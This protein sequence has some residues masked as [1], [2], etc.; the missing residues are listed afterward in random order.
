MGWVW[1]LAKRSV[2]EFNDDDCAHLAAGVAYYALFSL[3][4]LLLGII[5]ILGVI[6]GSSDV[7]Q[8]IMDRV[9]DL[10]PGSADIVAQ[11]IKGVVAS[12]QAI[13]VFSIVGFFWSASAIFAAIRRSLN[14]AWDVEQERPLLQQKLLEFGM[15]VGV[16]ILFLLSV[17]LTITFRVVWQYVPVGL[18]V[19]EGGI[20][21]QVAGNLVPLVWSFIIFALVY[22]FVPHA[23]IT[24]SDV[25]LGALVAAILFEVAKNAFVWYLANFAHYS[26][27]YGA[28]GVVIAFM[29]WAYLSAS[30]LLFG[31]ELASEYSRIRGS[32]RQGTS[33][34]TD[35][36]YRRS[37]VS[38]ALSSSSQ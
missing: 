11:N 27:V 32:Q 6:L 13:G 21:W 29:F 36:N 19:V 31:A 4:P 5:A 10:F 33:G 8:N 9:T 12:R 30:I 22:R 34:D 15:I 24:W 2:R 26:M 38:D 37:T 35:G 14:R 16:G 17:G 28:L 20:I 3:F 1:E 23:K 7:Q 25:W 18:R